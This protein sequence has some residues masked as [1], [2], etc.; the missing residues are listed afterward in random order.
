MGEEMEPNIPR[1]HS[2]ATEWRQDSIMISSHLFLSA[3]QRPELSMLE[4]MNEV[5][6]FEEFYNAMPVD[7]RFDGWSMVSTESTS[8]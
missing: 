8:V 6:P 4:I 2:I 7:D 5:T 1:R 3:K